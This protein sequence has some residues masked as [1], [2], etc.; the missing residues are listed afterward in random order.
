MTRLLRSKLANVKDEQRLIG[1]FRFARI[2][3]ILCRCFP[4]LLW[5]TQPQQAFVVK[6]CSNQRQFSNIPSSEDGAMSSKTLFGLP[7]VDTCPC[8]EVVG[9]GES[10]HVAFD[11]VSEIWHRVCGNCLQSETPQTLN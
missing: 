2:G 1:R 4:P 11:E 3:L 8:G 7:L 6:E 9:I 5:I 10:Q